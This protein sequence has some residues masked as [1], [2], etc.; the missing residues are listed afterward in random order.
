MD[1]LIYSQGQGTLTAPDGTVAH[2]YAGFGDG[3][4]NPGMENVP[5]VGPLPRGIYRIIGEPFDHP[6]CGPFCLRLEPDTGNA[7]YGRAGFLIHGDNGH[8]TASHGCIIMPRTMREQV[9][10]EGYLELEVTE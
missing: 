3:K 4:N 10:R 9:W 7:M 8:G 5:D 6:R 1:R 2:G